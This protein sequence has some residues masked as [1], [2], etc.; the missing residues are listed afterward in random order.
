MKKICLITGGTAGIGLST[1]KAMSNAGYVVYEISR[2]PQGNNFSIHC[3]G[4]ITDEKTLEPIINEIVNK[5]GK[6]DVVI[7][8]AGYGISG[9]VEFTEHTDAIKQFD[10]NFFGMVRVNKLIIPVMRKQGYGRI[11]NISSVAATIPIPFQT[12]YSASKAAV[13]SYTMSLANEVKSFGITVCAVQ[14]GDIKTEFTTSRNKS[15]KGNDVYK[16]SISKSVS[17][18]ENDE[19]GGMTPEYAGQFICNIARKRKIKP[20]YTIGFTYQILCFLANI[21]PKKFVNYIVKRLYL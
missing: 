9:A 11:I 12:Y 4:D 8:N 6:I 16:G 18:M 3:Q 20:I 17:K 21:L 10:V 19:Q 14:P 7:N 13:N 1:A 2:R 15:E 5:E